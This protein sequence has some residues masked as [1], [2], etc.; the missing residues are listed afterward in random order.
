[1][2]LLCGMPGD[3]Q[4][5]CVH[6]RIREYKLAHL[7][8]FQTE[9]GRVDLD[10]SIAAGKISG[11]IALNGTRYPLERF[12]GI[13][14]RLG[15][16]MEGR[17]QQKIG[18]LF[19]EWL[20]ISKAV[21]VNRPSSMSTN[22]SKTYQLQKIREFGFSVPETI[23]TNDPCSAGAFWQA[24]DRVIYKSVSSVRSIVRLLTP[25]DLP[26]LESIIW[27]PTQ[28]Q[29]YIAG[30]NVR[31]HTVGHEVLA[32]SIHTQAVDYRYA[33]RDG[34]E[35]ELRP[36]QLPSD[37]AAQCIRLSRALGL[38]FAGL[39][40]ILSEGGRYYCLEVN[41]SPAFSFYELRTG[42]TISRSLAQHLR[43]PSKSI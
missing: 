7:L 15:A 13:Y 32:S 6:Q 2:I 27:C 29:Q 8:V 18:A 28:F 10:L 5:A 16:E 21:V 9:F 26:R 34:F 37:V 4:I 12:S 25:S 40:L 35:L 31:V 1:M 19:G 30:L 41:P 17:H 3:A 24:F 33:E 38:T 22:F 11:W 36:F 23:V 42:Q 39:D 20:E 43:G 14:N